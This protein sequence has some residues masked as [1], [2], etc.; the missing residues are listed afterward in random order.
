MIETTNSSS[1]QAN[2]C[3]HLAHAAI[4]T[5]NA[6]AVA[7]QKSQSGILTYQEINFVTLHQRSDEIAYALNAYGIKSG[8]KAVLMV[9]PSIDFFAL[10]FALFKAGI[11][12]ILVD[13]G[14]GI[15]NLK[16]C[17]IESAPD[18]FIGIPK[19]HIAR[20]IF[21]WGK[22]SVKKCLTVGGSSVIAKLVA[23]VIGGD[24]LANILKR[25]PLNIEKDTDNKA[26]YPMVKL[27]DDAMSAIMFTSGSTGTPKGVVYSHKMFEAQITALKNDYAIEPGERDLATFPLFSLFG[28]ALG[29]ASIVPDMDASKPIR[30]NPH[31]IFAAI[32]KYQ[33]TNLFANPAL[34]EVLGQAGASDAQQDNSSVTKLTSLKRVISAGAPATLPSIARFTHL[35]NDNVPILTSY[36]ATE[37]LPLTKIASND[38]LETSHITDNGGGICVGRPISG[39]DIKIIKITEE[40]IEQW[41]DVLALGPNDIGEIVVKGD[42]VSQQYYQRDL[43]TAQAKIK[44][45]DGADNVRHRMGDLGYLDDNGLLWMCGRKAHRVETPKQVFYSIPCERIFNTHNL[46]KR[47]ALV[48]VKLLNVTTPVICIELTD[49]AKKLQKV[50][51]STFDESS[52]FSALRSIAFAHQQTAAISHFLIHDDFPVD[53]RHNAKIFREKL[54]VW[55][56]EELTDD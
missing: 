54:S 20:I 45:C 39:V 33:C 15:K 27:A 44:D 34:I 48:G 43:A 37:S 22:G 24:S 13:P 21:A 25:Y 18:A 29:M 23:K 28:P 3:R 26:T 4:A 8:M 32:E 36:G 31:Y 11:V 50:K 5:P 38:L 53:I 17:F 35:L 30:A 40:V 14:M 42:M 47:S 56:Q 16:Q 51:N 52:L 55:A 12:P 46:V 10:T 6:L 7:V 2:L 41:H 1:N 9:T 19:A 49:E